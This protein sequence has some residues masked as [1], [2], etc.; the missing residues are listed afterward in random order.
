MNTTNTFRLGIAFAVMSAV[1]FGVSGSFAKALLEAGWSPTAAVTARLAG[2]ALVVV[3]VATIVNR[4]WLSE[5]I[6]HGKTLIVYGVIPVAGVQLCY[7]NAVAHLSVGVALLLEYLSPVLVVGWVWASTRK[8]PKTST[9]VGAA[10]AL[11]GATIVLN[12]FA[13]AKIDI[14]GVAWALGATVCG[15]CYFLLSHRVSAGGGGLN[16]LTLAAGGLIIGAITVALLGMCGVFPMTFTS[17][18]TVIAGHATSFL[19]PVV[20]LGLVATAMAYLFGISGV[21]RLG[22][23]HASLMGLGEVL[24]AVAWAWLLVGEEITLAQAA[25]GGVV[26]L[27][28]LLASRNA[29]RTTAPATWPEVGIVDDLVVERG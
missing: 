23:S 6:A 3:L 19:V 12:V 24:C 7:Y 1:T 10:L 5:A 8:R 27:G 14:V 2:G 25:G 20:A 4:G 22:P 15:A 28:L 13:G 11:A 26:L 9:L 29:D 17:N 18:D 16:P 21:A